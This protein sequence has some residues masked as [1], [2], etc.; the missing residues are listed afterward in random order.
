[1]T[2]HPHMGAPPWW[3]EHW[4]QNCQEFRVERAGEPLGFVEQ[5]D[6][7]DGCAPGWL[8]IESGVAEPTTVR[9]P[10]AEV[11][12]VDPSRCLVTLRS[13]ALTAV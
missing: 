12:D 9:V 2:A 3:R 13:R 1:V 4:L 8:V 11:A 6:W 7:A 10:V 5:V